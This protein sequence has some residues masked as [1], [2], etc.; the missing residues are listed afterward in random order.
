MF[1]ANITLFFFYFSIIRYYRLYFIQ[2]LCYFLLFKIISFIFL[3]YSDYYLSSYAI[4]DL[5]IIDITSSYLSE[6]S[7]F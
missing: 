3:Y 4:I 7:E 6:K 1:I 5:V 2:S